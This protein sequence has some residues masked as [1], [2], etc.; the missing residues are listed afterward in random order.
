MASIL[1]ILF[2]LLY[3]RDGTTLSQQCSTSIF[4]EYMY[5]LSSE[6][7]CA[8]CI[9]CYNDANKFVSQ[10]TGIVKCKESIICVDCNEHCKSNFNSSQFNKDIDKIQSDTDVTCPILPQFISKMD[11]FHIHELNNES[12][13]SIDCNDSASIAV[14]YAFITPSRA[15]RE[16]TL[17]F[18]DKLKTQCEHQ[19]TC[20]FNDFSTETIMFGDD[21][22]D[23]IDYQAHI[24]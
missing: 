8:Q 18:S 17:D 15:N 11:G 5:C 20:V 16:C 7:K 12:E 3:F 19:K 4:Y 22:C 21:A 10:G 1:C 2:F 23:D 14:K 13:Y 6:S 9:P 24:G